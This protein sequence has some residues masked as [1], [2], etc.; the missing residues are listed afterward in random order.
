M[1]ATPAKLLPLIPIQKTTSHAGS[2][3]EEM[4]SDPGKQNLVKFVT[5]PKSNKFLSWYSDEQMAKI[6]R[7]IVLPSH[8]QYLQITTRRHDHLQNFNFWTVQLQAKIVRPWRADALHSHHNNE[9]QEESTGTSQKIHACNQKFSLRV[10]G[11]GSFC[12]PWNIQSSDQEW[13]LNQ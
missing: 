8:G 5:T 10:S 7:R 1:T 13:F 3:K 9:S 2:K 4:I 6:I 11:W 12:S